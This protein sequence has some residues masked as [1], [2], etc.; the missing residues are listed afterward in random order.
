MGEAIKVLVPQTTVAPKARREDRSSRI[1]RVLGSI[2]SKG[3]LTA[4]AVGGDAIVS[5][6]TI[7]Q[8]HAQRNCWIIRNKERS[9]RNVTHLADIASSS[10][11]PPGAHS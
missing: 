2:G 10:S 11:S 9:Q 1:Y 8:E 7:P 5:S 3:G 6:H 4:P